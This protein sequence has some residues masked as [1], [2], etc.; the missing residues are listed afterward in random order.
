[1]TAQFSND[2]SPFELRRSGGI[3][4]VENMIINRPIAVHLRLSHVLF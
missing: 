3:H 1:M 4:S 2:L